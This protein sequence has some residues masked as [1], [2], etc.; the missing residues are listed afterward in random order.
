[1]D[2]PALIQQV[3][4]YQSN[5]WRLVWSCKCCIPCQ[6]WYITLWLGWGYH[7]LG[8][9][10][11]LY[12][13]SFQYL[14]GISVQWVAVYLSWYVGACHFAAS[15]WV[16]KQ[17]LYPKTGSG[18][19]WCWGESGRL[20]KYYQFLWMIITPLIYS[21][22]CVQKK[23]NKYHSFWWWGRADDGSSGNGKDTDWVLRLTADPNDWLH[24]TPMWYLHQI[25]PFYI[26]IKREN[27]EELMFSNLKLHGLSIFFVQNYT[28]TSLIR[29]IDKN[30]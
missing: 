3:L 10:S 4:V 27:I 16:R 23:I 20:Y 7:I 24:L 6:W 15:C 13:C 18:Y 26:F 17:Q 8:S 5:G 21:L 19:C 22:V 2:W 1:M 9:I 14:C 12:I 28:C 25:E 11:F 30:I 29:Y